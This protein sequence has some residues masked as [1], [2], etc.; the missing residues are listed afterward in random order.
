M[1]T[2]DTYIHACMPAYLHPHVY[3]H[4]CVRLCHCLARFLFFLFVYP[5]VCLH[6]AVSRLVVAGIRRIWYLCALCRFISHTGFIGGSA[7]S[8]QHTVNLIYVCT[9]VSMCMCVCVF[10]RVDCVVDMINRF[11]PVAI[12]RIVRCVLSPLGFIGSLSCES[13]GH[14]T[15]RYVRTCYPLSDTPSHIHIFAHMKLMRLGKCVETRR[16]HHF[17]SKSTRPTTNKMSTSTKTTRKTS[18]SLYGFDFNVSVSW[19]FNRTPFLLLNLVSRHQFA[20]FL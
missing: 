16:W 20:Y 2:Y 7:N 6:N 14:A 1:L 3:A 4:A 5:F 10:A 11:V 13:S 12:L 8:K 9:L 15:Y 17:H 19:N 18:A